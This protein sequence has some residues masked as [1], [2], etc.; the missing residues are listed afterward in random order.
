[1]TWAGDDT[2]VCHFRKHEGREWE[3]VVRDDRAYVEWLMDDEEHDFEIGAVLYDHLMD[4][5]ENA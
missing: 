5:L 4:L 2:E 1:M 3:D